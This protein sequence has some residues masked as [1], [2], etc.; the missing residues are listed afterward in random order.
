MCSVCPDAE[1]TTEPVSEVV[2]ARRT[3]LGREVDGKDGVREWR[4]SMR[5]GRETGWTSGTPLRKA[6]VLTWTELS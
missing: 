6:K 5:V 1:V 2:E 3:M 4:I